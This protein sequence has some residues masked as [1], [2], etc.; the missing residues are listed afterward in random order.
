MATVNIKVINRKGQI[1][2]RSDKGSE[3]MFRGSILPETA[4]SGLVYQTVYM[5]FMRLDRNKDYTI[6]VTMDINVD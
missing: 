1:I 4:L 5:A 2:V 6:S 3:W